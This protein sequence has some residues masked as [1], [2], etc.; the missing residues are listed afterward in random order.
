MKK[1][2]GIYIHIPFC[3]RKCPYC[4][5]VSYDS[6]ENLIPDYLYA[7]RKEVICYSKY[8]RRPVDTI[9]FGGGTPNIL[10]AGTFEDIIN[11]INS[12][13]ETK[14][15][16]EI[17]V[18][19]NPGM[20]DKR[21]IRLLKS[22]GVNR[23]SFG[24]QSLDDNI[25]NFLGRIHSSEDFRKNYGWSRRIGFENISFDLLYG[26]PNQSFEKWKETLKESVL[27]A[28][29]HISAYSLEIEE[30]T[31][32]FK[33]GIHKVESDLEADM[34]IWAISYLEDRGYRQYEISNFSRPGFECLHNLH[35]WDESEYIGVGAGACGYLGGVRYRNS[36]GVLGYI[37]MV[38]KE[39]V[40]RV[41]KEV[42]EGRKKIFERLM[43]GLR[44]R[45]GLMLSKDIEMI[46]KDTIK[47]LI[48]NQFINIINSNL[49]LTEKGI[50]YYNKVISEF[51]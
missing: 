16:M 35:Y 51:I 4:S 5:F 7:L 33:N 15:D 38:K 3:K 12:R 2:I 47:D 18:E 44:K 49:Q 32:F 24:V 6:L 11:L 14:R 9:Y 34:Y 40:A 25:L 19:V 23:L 17:T 30:G 20:L 50:L 8:V 22:A 1:G 10:H 31:A 21:E 36:C 13:F 41:D 48:D 27:L 42:L 29:E 43:L 28:P 46:Y 45:E 39:G 37:N 26:I